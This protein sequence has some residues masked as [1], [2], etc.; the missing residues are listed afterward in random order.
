MA[1][2][3]VPFELVVS[4][5]VGTVVVT[6]QGELDAYTAPRLQSQLRDLINNQ[7]NLTVVLDL[8]TMTFIDST[9]LAVLV[10]ALKRIRSR[11][12]ELTLANPTRAT[13]RVLE[14]SGLNRV[15]MV[16]G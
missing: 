12:G 7:G 10:E 16:R 4:R 14:V 15:F 1:P 6:I 9:G 5:A 8:A 3:E 13:L 11:G 2:A